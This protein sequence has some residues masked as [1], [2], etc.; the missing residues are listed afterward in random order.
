MDNIDRLVRIKSGSVTDALMEA[1]EQAEE[2]KTCIILYE[3]EGF[4]GFI[5]SDSATFKDAYYMADMFK[6]YL[7][8]WALEGEEEK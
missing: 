8:R 2:F 5:N 1:M 6:A 3:K 4:S 7:L